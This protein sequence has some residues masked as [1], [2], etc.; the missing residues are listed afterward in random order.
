M[1]VCGLVAVVLALLPLSARGQLVAQMRRD[2]PFTATKT[3]TVNRP[4]EN[5]TVS[6]TVARDSDGS[7]YE[8]IPDARTGEIYI[9]LIQDRAHGRSVQLIPAKKQYVVR[10]VVYPPLPPH[11]RDSAEIQKQMDY[12]KSLQPSKSKSDDG[13][14]IEETPLGFRTRDG[15]VEFGVRRVHSNLPSTSRLVE[16]EWETWTI[17]AEDIGSETAG[18]GENH[19]LRMDTRVTKIEIGELDRHLFDIPPDYTLQPPQGS[20]VPVVSH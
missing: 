3:V 20:G 11:P 17:P 14:V 1:R 4:G 12:L 6:S 10:D 9:I 18:Y 13:A 5:Y 15:F 19:E 16:R 2:R 8:E 7:T